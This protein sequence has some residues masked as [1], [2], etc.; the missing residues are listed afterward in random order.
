MQPL[1]LGLTQSR[2]GWGA[3][4]E[5]HPLKREL[6]LPGEAQA[7]EKGGPW[8]IFVEEPEHEDATGGAT[9]R[10]RRRFHMDASPWAPRKKEGNSHDYYETEE[11]MRATF[12]Y[13]WG[14]RLQDARPANMGPEVRSAGREAPQLV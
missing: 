13:D 3:V 5:D 12:D 14:S 4:Q 2:K 1:R 9:K 6:G 8:G 10:V 11:A 7:A